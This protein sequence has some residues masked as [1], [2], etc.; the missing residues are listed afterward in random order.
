MALDL[1]LIRNDAAIERNRRRQVGTGEH[2]TCLCCGADIKR[3]DRALYVYV[4]DGGCTIVTEAEAAERNS[5]PN[6]SSS[7]CGYHPIGPECARKHREELA[8]YRNDP[9]RYV[10][11]LARGGV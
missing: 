4:H 1:D 10:P 7:D 3:P 9:D 8:P 5:E 11:S 6:G 2:G